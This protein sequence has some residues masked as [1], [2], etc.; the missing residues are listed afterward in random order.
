MVPYC[1]LWEPLGFFFTKDFPMTLIFLGYFWLW[2]ILCICWVDGY[3][4][5]EILI[6]LV[7]SWLFVLPWDKLCFLCIMG[8]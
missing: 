7:S 5:Y 6:G 8:S 4:S 1:M 3:S 2:G